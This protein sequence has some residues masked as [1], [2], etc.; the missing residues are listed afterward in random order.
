MSAWI[1]AWVSASWATVVVWARP[2]ADATFCAITVLLWCVP[3]LRIVEIELAP[4]CTCA[5]A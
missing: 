5:V 1:F 3:G 4:I 2:A